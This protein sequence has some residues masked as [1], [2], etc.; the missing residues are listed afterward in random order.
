MMKKNTSRRP[1]GMREEPIKV[2]QGV[3]TFSYKDP[4]MLRKFMTERGDILARSKT[5]I[6]AKLQRL[7]SREVKRARHLALLPFVTTL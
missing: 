7:L 6:D 3:T 2:P 5:G 1:R 4:E